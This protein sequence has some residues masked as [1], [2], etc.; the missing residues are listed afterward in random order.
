MSQSNKIKMK[1]VAPKKT[2]EDIEKL[3]HRSHILKLPDTYLGSIEVDNDEKW[4][5]DSETKKILKANKE[6]D[7]Q[8]AASFYQYTKDYLYDIIFVH[9]FQL[10]VYTPSNSNKS[11]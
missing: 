9:C 8:N 4:F 6:I 1:V 2:N 5:F 10:K 11:V 3:D 7:Y